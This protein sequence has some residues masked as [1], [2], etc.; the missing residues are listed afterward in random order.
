MDTH[1]E[2]EGRCF[3]RAFGKS[4]GQ[5]G[6]VAQRTVETLSQ[7]VKPETRANLELGS[8]EDKRKQEQICF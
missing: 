2:H 7:L 6:F 4:H 5:A 3:D 8:L 1:H